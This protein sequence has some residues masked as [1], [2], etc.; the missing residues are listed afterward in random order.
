MVL[1]SPLKIEYVVWLVVVVTPQAVTAV[2]ALRRI[3]K[4]RTGRLFPDMG[5]LFANSMVSG[6]SGVPWDSERKALR[7]GEMSVGQ[8][9]TTARM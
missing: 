3:N 8:E 2:W 9:W 7:G 6:H 5:Q 1:L 4:Q